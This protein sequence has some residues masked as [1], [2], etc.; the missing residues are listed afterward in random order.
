VLVPV[1]AAVFLFVLPV[2]GAQGPSGRPVRI[3][4]LHLQPIMPD[5]SP[6]RSAFLD[7]LRGLGY[8]VGRNLTI[9]YRSGLM[10]PELLPD[11]VEELVAAK[12]DV[13]V[14]VGIE[15][16]KAAKDGTKSVP[17]VV[18]AVADPV[19]GGLVASLARPGGNVTGLTFVAPELAGKRLQLLLEAFP[20]ATRVAVLW[21]GGNSGA[22]SEWQAGEA[23]ARS[24][25]LTLQPLQVRSLQELPARLSG[26]GRDRPD[27]L[28]VIGDPMT[29]SARHIIVEA[30]ARHRL[31]AMYSWREFVDVGGLMVYS[32]PFPDLFRRAALYVDRILKGAKPADLPVEQPGKFE[33]VINLKTAKALGL[34][35]P[36]TLVLRADQLIE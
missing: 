27:A 28:Y 6:E 31:P 24:L 9:E 33:L 11:L 30:T 34:A 25:G 7:A 4:Y 32:A 18:P 10:R 19:G 1:L 26:L 23:A 8:E 14:A 36:S 15:A 16:A 22:Q 3:G 20:R 12:V 17:I 21:N 5:P 29:S 35:I 2:A 13:I